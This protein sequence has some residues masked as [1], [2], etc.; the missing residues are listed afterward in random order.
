MPC[1]IDSY[2]TISALGASTEEILS[3]LNCSEMEFLS[4]SEELHE[5]RAV[6]VGM[7]KAILPELPE[8]LSR[9]NCRNNRLTYALFQKIEKRF[10]ELKS[11]VGAHR[12]GIVIG[13]STSGISSLEMALKDVSKGKDLP[14]WYDYA[15]SEVSGTSNFL[16]DLTGV[17]GPTYSV[18]TACT[19]SMKALG[20]A[21]ALL[22]SGICDV[23]L[24]GGID[25]LC[26]LTVQGFGSLELLSE[27]VANP[28]SV[29]RDG[30]N[31][32]EGGGLCIL[33]KEEGGVQICSIGESSDAYHISAPH[34]EGE[35][36]R[37]AISSALEAAKITPK[38]VDYI[39]LH[40]TGT[41]FNDIAE[42]HA[43]GAIFGDSVPCSSIK[44]LVGHT[45][46][47][48][49]VLGVLLT[50]MT[51]GEAERPFF[52]GQKWD[53][54]MDPEMSAISIL[55]ENRQVPEKSVIYT[56]VNNI[57][58]GGNNCAIVLSTDRSDA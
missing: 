56:V 6:M 22:D 32:G 3:N 5:E 9:Y 25:S 7:V 14:E 21:K 41:H 39:Q 4:N 45:L 23:V 33:T 36:S 52:P 24:T 51:T 1:K 17:T 54:V 38:D 15:Q 40:G 10:E 18:S 19:S 30:I 57:A 2:A 12:I 11:S 28:H 16:A 58:F 20:S 50:A 47:A 55:S 48:S 35:G 43:V 13:S 26:K 49:G 31:I 53:G 8:Y 42:S 29:N 37:K 46:G 27:N 34:P 44:P